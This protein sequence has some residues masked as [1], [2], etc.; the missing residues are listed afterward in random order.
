MIETYRDR[1]KRIDSLRAA[2]DAGAVRVAEAQQ[3][4]A[5]IESRWLPELEM[6]VGHVN[7]RFGAAFERMRCAG[8]VRLAR[9]GTY[10]RWGIDIYVK[11]RD[12]EQLQLLTGQRQ[13]GGVR[14]VLTRNARCR[15]SCTC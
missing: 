1:L 8:E 6:V 15:L 11:F 3:H 13:S 9:E 14:L 4:I 5:R 2:I 12:T 7:T 10:D